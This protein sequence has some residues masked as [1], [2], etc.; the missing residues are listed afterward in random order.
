MIDLTPLDV[1]KK[2][3]DLRKVLRGYDPDE[4]EGFLQLAAERLEE[5]VKENLT[6]RERTERLQQ[7]VLAHEGRENAV[8][9]ALVVAQQ[10][11][12]DLKVQTEREA[13]LARQE[14]EAEVERATAEVQRRLEDAR[15]TLA[16]L[17]QRRLRFLKSFRSMLERE[18]ESVAVEEGRAPE[19]EMVAID[20]DLGVKRGGRRKERG[21]D[22]PADESGKAPA[23]ATATAT[24]PA[25]SDGEA[26]GAPA[27]GPEDPAAPDTLWLS[28]ILQEADGHRR[29]R[30]EGSSP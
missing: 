6:L 12:A 16:E 30:E 11:R 28:S 4:V 19:E 1:R 18:I 26:D 24:A 3:G 8:Q 22:E 17:E 23:D 27:P 2:A 9:E 25:G 14:I 15:R 20:L 10:L 7:Q 13:D 29:G 5:L 21:R